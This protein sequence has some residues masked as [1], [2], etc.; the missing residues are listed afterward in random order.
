MGN[1]R[2]RSGSRVS[3]KERIGCYK[4]RIYDHFM[5][6]CPTSKEEREIEQIQQMF[7]VGKEKTPLK[8]LDANTYVSLNKMNSLENIRQGHLNL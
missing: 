1:S 2:S 3:K 8:M 6:D 4:C 5:K 7:Y